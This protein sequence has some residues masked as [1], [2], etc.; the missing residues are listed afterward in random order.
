MT[1]SSIGPSR[2]RVLVLATVLACAFL[3]LLI[4]LVAL[5]IFQHDELSRLAEAQRSKTIALRPK[6]GPIVD[7]NGR[8]LGVSVTTE[9]LY[10][11]PARIEDPARLAQLLA[12]LLGESA[13]AIAKRLATDRPFIWVKRKLPPSVARSLRGLVEP[14]LGLVQDSLRLYPNRGLAA[15]VLGFVGVDDHGLEGVELAWDHHL[16]GRPGLALVERDARGREV[17][18]R[19]SVLKPSVR[20]RGVQLTLDSTIQ[21][22]AEREIDLVWRRTKAKVAMAVMVEPRTGELLAVAIR[23]T[24]NPNSFV[25]ARPAEW[26][27]RAITDP[28]EPGSIF[29][30]V[31]AAAALEEGVVRP[32][33]LVYAEQGAI[34][35]ANTV[36]HD[37]K[38]YGWLT[39]SEVLQRSSNVGAVKV[40]V[41]LGG[42]RFSRYIGKFG[43]GSLSGLG[44]PGESRGRVW[45]LSRWSKLSLAAL[46]IGH[47]I[48]V[49][50]LQMVMAFAAVA[51]GGELLQ[52]QVVRTLLDADGLPLG[53]F[54]P[55]V[56]RRVVSPAT[57][58]ALTRILTRVVREGTGQNAAIRGYDVAGKTGT[59]QKLDPVTRRYSRK[60]GVLSFVGFAPAEEPRVAMLVLVD[61]PANARWGSEV[62]APIFSAIGRATLEYLNVPPRDTAPVQIV[63][64]LPAGLVIPVSRAESGTWNAE[65]PRMPSLVGKPLR[66]ALAALAA[67]EMQVEIHGGGVVV[68]QKPAAGVRIERGMRCRLDLA[69]PTGRQ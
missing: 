48:S 31:L 4:R 36:I 54:E 57:S 62:A 6:R 56:I 3:G 15:H 22:L 60:P 66:L 11:H 28:F 63:R 27:N 20:G 67:Y 16:A 19:L 8:P 53:V 49:T 52:P 25:K 47:E 55:R 68:A 21:Y 34:T 45:S 61:E 51:N 13:R 17:S 14:G 42:E 44:L 9:S 59:A 30:V 69:P 58:R 64:S 38:R 12:P 35:V 1:E 40:G 65:W 43:F 33:D 23:P 10:A 50:P 7:R 32:G 18:G 5:Q 26:R 2:S 39:F 37:W 46:S 41:A 29:K 24:F